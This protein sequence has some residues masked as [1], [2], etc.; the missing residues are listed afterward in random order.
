M[1]RICRSGTDEN[2]MVN[3]DCQ[4]ND[5]FLTTAESESYNM[6]KPSEASISAEGI[7]LL[8]WNCSKMAARL[9]IWAFL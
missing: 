4:D 9:S 5:M 7:L 1:T 8:M 2:A 6:S 3:Y